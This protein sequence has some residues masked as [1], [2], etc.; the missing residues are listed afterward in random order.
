MLAEMATPGL[1]KIKVFRNK[2]YYVIISVHDVTKK[3]YQTT[4]IILRMWSCDQSLIILAFL[5]EKLSSPQFYKD[6]TRKTAF[7]EG[8]PW[9]KF[10]NLGLALGKNLKFCT[11]V[12]KGLIK[13]KVTKF[14]GIAPTFV[15]ITGEKLVRGVFLPPRPSSLLPSSWIWLTFR[16]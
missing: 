5:W 2:D 8:W 14:W 13:L 9:F 4:Q 15:E 12:A 10:N 7:F 6:L 11:S 3:C 1:L 16:L